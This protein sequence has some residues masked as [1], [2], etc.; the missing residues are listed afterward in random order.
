MT[1]VIKL[2][3]FNLGGIKGKAAV[4]TTTSTKGKYNGERKQKIN[5]RAKGRM[6]LTKGM[7]PCAAE[8]FFPILGLHETGWNYRLPFPSNFFFSEKRNIFFCLK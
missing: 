8:N 2:L 6:D 1:P 7:F 3:A 4:A 5:K